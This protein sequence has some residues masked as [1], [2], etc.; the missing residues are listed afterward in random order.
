MTWEE[1]A[2]D[3]GVHPKEIREL[4]KTANV[5]TGIRHASKSG[6]KLRADIGNYGTWVCGLFDAI[7]AARARL[8]AGFHSM[9][10]EEVAD[11]VLRGAPI[12][13]YE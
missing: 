2:R 1:L 10:P 8:E 7:N 11:A 3:I 12:I 6:K 9:S 4:K 13:P 5:E